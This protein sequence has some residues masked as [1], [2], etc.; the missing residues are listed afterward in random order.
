MGVRAPGPAR[1]A[2]VYRLKKSGPKRG[3]SGDGR[4]RNKTLA[5]GVAFDIRVALYLRKKS[6]A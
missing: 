3:G 2:S 4:L 1:G 6:A 5:V